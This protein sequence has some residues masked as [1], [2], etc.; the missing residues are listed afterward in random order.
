MTTHPAAAKAPSPQLLAVMDALKAGD[1]ATAL[2]TAETGLAD[3]GADRPPFLA[4]AGLAAQRLGEP[5]KAVGHL[6]ELLDLNPGDNATRSNLAKALIEIQAL[7]EALAIAAGGPTPS[8][9]R[10]EGYVRQ[11]QDDLAGAAAAYRRVLAQEPNDPA[12]LNNLGNVLG[13]MGDYD[14]AIDAFEKAITHAPAEVEIY[15]N[16]ANVLRQA[17]R[18]EARLKVMRDAVS[19]APDNRLA[20]TELALALA[21]DDKFDEAL[22]LLETISRRFPE[23]GESQLE[24]GRMYE[25]YNRIDDLAALVASFQ[26]SNPPPE[27]GFLHAWLAQRQGSFDDAAALAAAIPESIHPMRRFHLIGSIEERRGNAATAFAAFERMNRE[28]LV[29][30]S[31]PAKE[32][33]RQSIERKLTHWTPEWATRWEARPA[34]DD[35]RRDPIFLVGFPRSGTTL[36]DTMLMGIPSVSVLEER[37]MVAFTAQSLD[38]ADLP[39]LAPETIADVRA[40]YFAIARKYGWDETRWLVD[41]QPLN[42]VHA[43]LIHRLFPAARFILA[44]R[45]PYDVVLSCFMANFQVNFAMRSFTSLEEA[46]WTYDAVFRAWTTATTLLN[47]S[48]STVEY[49]KLVVDPGGELAPLINRLGLPWNDRVLD[50]TH[51]AKDRGRV[52][53][54]SYSQ[55]GEPLYDRARY[56]WKRYAEQLAP[57]IPILEPWATRFGYE[58]I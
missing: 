3:A 54:A 19:L 43:P 1:F 10:I 17:D 26:G 53:T 56:R 21:H 41:K 14:E 48:F 18:S 15:L 40:E 42:M 4:F 8:L 5:A 49:E 55:I 12:S 46:A 23:F 52:R 6:S 39:A 30:P 33:Y 58:T 47:I 24:L 22:G 2:A 16:L 28:T 7:D 25:S 45:H 38:D 36:L 50:H 35:S 32:S 44:K 34:M 29:A 11:E 13:E 20:L 37:P 27:V 9:A 31:P 57:V 51:T